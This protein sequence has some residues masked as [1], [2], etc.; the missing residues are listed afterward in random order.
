[1]HQKYR[2]V[3]HHMGKWANSS[4][5]LSQ[6]IRSSCWSTHEAYHATTGCADHHRQYNLHPNSKLSLLLEDCLMSQHATDASNLAAARLA[7]ACAMADAS[8]YKLLLPWLEEMMWRG[9]QSRT[10][11]LAAA[12]ERSSE[13]SYLSLSDMT[14][15][16]VLVWMSGQS[17][18]NIAV[19]SNAIMV[20][21]LAASQSLPHLLYC[22][23]SEREHTWHIRIVA[24]VLTVACN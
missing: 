9:Q 7:S 2:T 4:L 18:L 21:K 5:R 15:H 22:H 16:I 14:L 11:M 12:G 3:K 19:M 1:M 6:V 17:Q 13:T 23:W 24:M 10:Q 20:L 8:T